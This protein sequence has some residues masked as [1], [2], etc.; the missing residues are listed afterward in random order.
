[1]SPSGLRRGRGQGRSRASGRRRAPSLDRPERSPK[2]VAVTAAARRV[3]VKPR[4]SVVHSAG[5]DSDARGERPPVVGA[6]G[7]PR[8]PVKPTEEPGGR[9]PLAWDRDWDRKRDQ[10]CR[11]R[12]P[13]LQAETHEHGASH[14]VSRWAQTGAR[15]PRRQRGPDETIS[16]AGMGR[17]GHVAQGVVFDDSAAHEVHGACAVAP[18]NRRL[19]APTE[20]VE[21]GRPHVR[22]V[23][24][25][26][27]RCEFGRRDRLTSHPRTPRQG[28]CQRFKATRMRPAQCVPR[29][30]CPVG[31]MGLAARF[32]NAARRENRGLLR[33]SQCDNVTVRVDG[34]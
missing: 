1:M 34:W 3:L 23:D 18:K 19:G 14:G 13:V 17:E 31:L 29:G 32:P 10:R 11:R 24:R 12:G 25:R 15:S 20:G 6:A 9:S 5:A 8:A 26:G 16:G 7:A 28:C 22:A 2:M 33:M 4:A 21:A 27:C 30:Q